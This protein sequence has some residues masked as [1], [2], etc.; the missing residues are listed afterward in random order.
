MRGR[1]WIASVTI[2]LLLGPALLGSGLPAPAANSPLPVLQGTLAVN[3]LEEQGLYGSLQEA[4]AAARYGVYQVS[5]DSSEWLAD[6]PAQQLR[7]RFTTAG[8]QLDSAGDGG[9]HRF[10]MRLRSAGY[11]DRQITAAAGRLTASGARAEIR[12]DL[13][14]GEFSQTRSQ[15]IEWYHNRAEGLEQ[16]FTLE[17]RAGRAPG[18]R[19]APGGARARWRAARRGGG[20]R[21][22]AG[23]QGRG[24]RQGIAVRPPGGDRW[25][26][27]SAAGGHGGK[28]ARSARSGS[29]STTAA[30]PGR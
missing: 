15:I 8:L 12:H 1:T 11:G 25:R 10:A 30:P 3:H 20:R 5:T 29:R 19:T 13:Q 27:S 4:V 24:W 16:G 14:P 6:N 22:G 17:S 7:A 23:V 18:R 21:A 9:A 28:R 2:A 26:R